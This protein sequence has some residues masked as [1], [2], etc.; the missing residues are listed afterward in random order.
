[1]KNMYKILLT[2]ILVIAEI[3]ILTS[4]VF[5]G[6]PSIKLSGESKT[7]I[8]WRSTQLQGAAV[9]DE[10]RL[11][12]RDDAGNGMGRFRLN[13]D[14]ENGNN[15]G[16][17]VR[18]QWESWNNDRNV[19]W[20]YAFGYGNFFEDQMT[21]SVGKLGGSPW[22]TGGP[23]MWK[24][25]EENNSGGGM[26]IEWKPAFVP[27]K[28][29]LGF[30]LNYYNADRDQGIP[31]EDFKLT[32]IDLLRESVLGV[33]YTHDDWGLIRLAYRLDSD[34]DAFQDNKFLENGGKGE[35]EFAYRIEE[36]LLRNYLPGM[37]IWALGHLVG[38]SAINKEIQWF[39]NWLFAEYSPPELFDLATPFT[40]QLRFGINYVDTRSE[41]LFKPSFYWHF[42]NKLIS[43]G[44]AFT[45]NQDFG[46]KLTEGSPFQ[47]IELEPKVQLNFTSSYIAFVYC[48]RR[49]YI[50]E[51]QAVEG[52]DPIKQT[53]WMNLRFCIYF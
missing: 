15:F 25:L 16:F 33:S 40:A 53:H 18:M 13:M 30:V 17:K 9:E 29:N 34:M 6:D 21:V 44:A 37:Q 14:Y 11:H 36:Y 46:N 5:A 12:S 20:M 43:V 39:R 47:Y 28:L 51:A 23:E 1:M 24:E 52:Y 42:L 8:D 45:Y 35:D 19:P 3:A 26:R 49:E 50:H 4:P 10:L 22:G 27:G 32:L 41:F 31:A 7:G 2:V 48:F 38:L